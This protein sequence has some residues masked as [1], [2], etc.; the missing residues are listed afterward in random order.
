M[1]GDGCLSFRREKFIEFGGPDGG[2]GGKGGDIWFFADRNIGTLLD[3]ARRPKL[4]ALDG[5]KGMGGNKTG[6]SAE[7]LVVPV[8]IGTVIYKNDRL[9]ADLSKEGDRVLVAK[10]GRGG[11]G[12][13]SFKSQ[14][15]T[16]PRIA[17]K[18]QPGE[19]A[20]L[21]LELKLIA[22]V[23]LAGFPNAGKST[24]LS[25]MSHARPKIADYPFTTLVPHLGVVE[26]K[27]SSFIMADIPGLIEGA[28]TGKGLGDDFLRHVERTRL[29]VH[30]IDP[31]GFMGTGAVDGIRVIEGELKSFSSRL[32]TKPRLM[33]V[34][35]LDL[36]EGAKVL[37]AVKRRY[38]ARKVFGISCAT[39]QGIPELADFLLTELQ[40]L[41]KDA[42]FKMPPSE[43]LHHEVLPGYKVTKEQGVWHVRGPYV[44]RVANMTDMRL[45]E[46][47]ARFQLAIKKIGV[48]KSL[49]KAGAREGDDVR[50]GSVEFVWT[51]AP[52]EAPPRLPRTRRIRLE[53]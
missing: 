25:R 37:E 15:I 14:R 28:H 42:G 16:T 30:M 36:P 52:F 49:K 32:A 34:N 6:W 27:K 53:Q 45:P 5:H 29:L 33:V 40:R 41:P 26:H 10:G 20:E 39:G 43:M 24:L 21:E 4:L 50:I 8:P 38:R 48:D 23:G 44:E 1:G 11:R 2:D 47:I 13:L 46:A 22:D 7:D 51:D 31:L 17:E 12:N 18:G 9:L 19:S 3:L 35:K